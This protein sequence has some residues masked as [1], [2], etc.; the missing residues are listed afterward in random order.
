[1]ATAARVCVW[2]ARGNRTV[3]VRRLAG[4]PHG[5]FVPPPYLADQASRDV[6]DLGAPADRGAVYRMLL[7]S[8][9]AEDITRWVN[10]DVL[11]DCLDNLGLAPHVVA[12]WRQALRELGAP[13]ETTAEVA[14]TGV[15]ALESAGRGGPTRGRP[16]AP[17]A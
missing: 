14:G 7:S 13:A 4:P 8:G 17:A 2:A 3:D 5:W 10:V 16:T 11:A 1:M 12:P 6:Y 9:T 15:R